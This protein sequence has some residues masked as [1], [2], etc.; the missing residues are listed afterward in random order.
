MLA[1]NLEYVPKIKL[2][3]FVSYKTPWIHFK[4]NIDEYVLYFIKSGKLHIEE[5][6]SRY[7][8]GRG[9]MFVLEPNLD[10]EGFD[11]H[12]CD[13]YYVH[14]AHPQMSWRDV[15]DTAALARRYLF[16]DG[17]AHSIQDSNTCY[18][19]KFSTLANKTS[20]HYTFHAMD[21]ML[22]LYQRKN[23]NRSLTALKLSELFINLSR[24]NLLNQLQKE[25]SKKTKSFIKVHALLDH[26]HQNYSQKIMG[27]EIEQRF[28]CN[29]DYMNRIFNKV[30]GH[31]ITQ[32]VNL[33]RIDHAKELIEAT[34]LSI[35]EIGYLT[36]LNDPY[37]FSKVFKKY[38][39]LSP[40]QYYK[41]IR[42]DA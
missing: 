17:S 6:G 37:Y 9:D 28:E 32:Y 16:E 18:L 39:G 8:L 31:T 29:Y 38:T 11:K 4:R 24:E 41:K 34:H 33:I 22:N 35:G 26:I 2:V 14:F 21:E 13:Y 36:G 23:Y 40:T 19:P 1:V 20:L 5:N 7:T 10:H 3:G 42:E 30:T 25:S 27:S 12:E 15:K